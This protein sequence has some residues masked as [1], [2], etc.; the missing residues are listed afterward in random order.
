MS[1]TH[2]VTIS[3]ALVKVTSV[4]D[5]ASLKT[6]SLGIEQPA[7]HFENEG[8]TATLNAE[9]GKLELVNVAPGDEAKFDIK[10]TNTSTI[11]VRY[12]VT[13]W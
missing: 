9:T 12:E 11:G 4:I 2:E 1:N 10:L 13:T 6:Y 5:A 7:G 3:T 8:S